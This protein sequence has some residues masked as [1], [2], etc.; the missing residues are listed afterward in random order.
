MK[1]LIVI[2][3]VLIV[4]LS[5]SQKDANPFSEKTFY[6]NIE[7][8]HYNVTTYDFFAL[9]KQE[10]LQALNTIKP[11]NNSEGKFPFYSNEDQSLFDVKETVPQKSIL[12]L[13]N[14]ITIKNNNDFIDKVIL[15]IL[16]DKKIDIVD[17]QN[18]LDFNGDKNINFYKNYT[19]DVNKLI[20]A[21]KLKGETEFQIGMDINNFMN[22]TLKTEL[23]RAL[24][25]SINLFVI[26]F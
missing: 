12:N 3:C 5:F 6:S 8:N 20:I 13:S 15:K 17:F 21:Y 19:T 2:A 25:N 4:N 22:K 23:D 1:N 16:E 11:V 18:T 10:E 26:N 24:Q 9:E 14:V 7:E